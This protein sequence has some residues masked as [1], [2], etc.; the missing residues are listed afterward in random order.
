MNN[1]ALLNELLC[2]RAEVRQSVPLIHYMTNHISSE[3]C[4]NG[5]LALGASPIFAEHPAEAEEITKRAKAFAINLGG[6]SDVRME[7]A[8]KSGRVALERKIP[9]VIDLV[10]V[11]CS[12]LRMDCAE[13]FIGECR[14]SIIKG[15]FSEIMSICKKGG[16]AKGVD[17]AGEAERDLEELKAAMRELS[18]RTEAVVV[19]TGEI[20]LAV[21]QSEIYSIYNGNPM[22]SKITGTGCLF[23]ALTAT[24]ISGG[25]I[26]EG[27]VLAAIIL[28]ICGEMA[29]GATGPGSFRTALLD[30][31]YNIDYDCILTRGRVDFEA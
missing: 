9:S 29:E 23:T 1:K 4:A 7:A 3:L 10:G 11:G 15:N 19:C 31:I 17:A 12:K 27:A 18:V 6:I 13:K 21:T 14:P 28:G 22:L 24:L 20:D 25:E 5:I 30:G 26:L 16:N 8:L 2:I